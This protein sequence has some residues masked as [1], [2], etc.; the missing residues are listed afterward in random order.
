LLKSI[1]LDTCPILKKGEN[2]ASSKKIELEGLYF[3]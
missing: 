1:Y 3:L 2:L